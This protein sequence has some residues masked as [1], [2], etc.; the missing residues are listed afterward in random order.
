M[1]ITILNPKK[2][3]HIIHLSDNLSF[4]K[5]YILHSRRLGIPIWKIKKIVGYFVSKENGTE[6]QKAQITRDFNAK[7][8][9]ISLLTRYQSIVKNKSNNKLE[10]TGYL[11]VP[12]SY[13]YEVTLDNLAHE[14][15]HLIE[16]DHTNDRYILEKRLSFSFAYLARNLGYKGYKP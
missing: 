4:L 12:S 13:L 10:M 14:L 6:Q 8:Y 2:Q 7:Q 16:W 5:P 9:T 15:S 11:N 1:K 3:K